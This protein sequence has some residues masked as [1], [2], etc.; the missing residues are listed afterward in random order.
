[1]KLCA[2]IL[3]LISLSA[4]GE[5]TVGLFNADKVCL[6]SA[7]EGQLFNDG[8]ALANVTITRTADYGGK[9]YTDTATTNS[10]GVFRFDA[11]WGESRLGDLVQFVSHQAMFVE[12][13]GDRQQIWGGGKS[14]PEEYAEFGGK[15]DN[16]TCD[17]QNPL[18]RS[19]K[20]DSMI[21]GLCRWDI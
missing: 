1:M 6:F 8:K 18:Q 20:T 21:G 7:F 5:N 11:R 9:T 13:Q 4:C 15:P 19:D 12:Y 17:L 3:C 14:S 10:D 2:V 16:L